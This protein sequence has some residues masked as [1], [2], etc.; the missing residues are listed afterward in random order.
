MVTGFK[1]NGLGFTVYHQM[2]RVTGLGCRVRGDGFKVTD[3]GFR[4]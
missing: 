4:V 3:L 1:F 2:L